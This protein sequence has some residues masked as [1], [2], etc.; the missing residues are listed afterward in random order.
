MLKY[1]D[2]TL[3][4]VNIYGYNTKPENDK[5]LNSIERRLDFW[6]S[7]FPNSILLI[8]GDFNIALDNAADRWPPGQPSSLNSN[9]KAFMQKFDVIDVWRR[10]ISR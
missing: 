1:L 10:E 6:L 9:L 4:T 3:I 2:A 8:G 7:R 5:L